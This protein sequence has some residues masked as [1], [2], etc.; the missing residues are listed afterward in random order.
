MSKGKYAGIVLKSNGQVGA[1]AF[2]INSFRNSKNR[3]I[4]LGYSPVSLAGGYSA[5]WRI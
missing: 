5:T 2:N 1:I 4:S 3:R